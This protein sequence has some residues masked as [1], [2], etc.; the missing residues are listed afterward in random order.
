[1]KQCQSCGMPLQTSQD[2]RGTEADGSPSETWCSLCYRDGAFIDPNCTV[3][4]MQQIV[5]T[6]LRERG[7]HRAFREIAMK[8]IPSLARWR[9]N[10]TTA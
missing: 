4:Q 2:C 10:A 5:D 8:Q 3:E 1:M 6:A 9:A 7:S